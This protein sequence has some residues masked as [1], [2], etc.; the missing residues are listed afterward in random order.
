MRLGYTI[1][2]EQQRMHTRLILTCCSAPEFKI[3]SGRYAVL[4]VVF[5]IFLGNTTTS[6]V[7]QA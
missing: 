3:K 6:P 7:T 2:E 1:F 4:E 5:A